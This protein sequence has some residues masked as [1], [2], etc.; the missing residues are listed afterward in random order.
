[1]TQVIPRLKLNLILLADVKISI[2]Y[3]HNVQPD[4]EEF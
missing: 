2:V 4:K 3:V 1:M